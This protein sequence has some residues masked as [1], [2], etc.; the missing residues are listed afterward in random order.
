[1]ISQKH[2]FHG[3]LQLKGL[4]TRGKTFKDRQGRFLIKY[5]KSKQPNWRLAI[6]VSRKVNKKAV[7]R[8]RIRRRSYEFFR[9]SL[10]DDPVLVDI[11]VVVKDDALATIDSLDIYQ[12]A[13][14]QIRQVSSFKK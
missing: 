11:V 5:A 3:R 8:N 12:P 2:R 7:I 6:V 9:K 1:M 10:K 13:I 4:F 14:D